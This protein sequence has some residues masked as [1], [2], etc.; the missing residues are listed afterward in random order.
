EAQFRLPTEMEWEWAARGGRQLSPYPWGGP[1]VLNKKGCYLANFKPLP[2]DYAADGGLYTVRANA[3]TPNDYGLYNMSGNVAEWTSD[4]YA[5]SA[6]NTNMYNDINPR[7]NYRIQEDDPSWV[8][9]KIV[10]GG[11]WRDTKD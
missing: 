2:G 8:R 6:Y 11:S 3:Y 1:Y 5:H 9:R 10:K 7:N 4:S